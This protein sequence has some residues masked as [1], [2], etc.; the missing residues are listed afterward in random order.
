MSS[1]PSVSGQT[2]L[3]SAYYS[4]AITQEE[5]NILT[6]AQSLVFH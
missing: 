5:S 6:S 4:D 2:G 1:W 3:P